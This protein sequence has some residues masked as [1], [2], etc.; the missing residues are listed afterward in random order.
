MQDFKRALA[1]LVLMGSIS[2]TSYPMPGQITRR[3]H[4]SYT[5][6]IDR[7]YE[8]RKPLQVC[9]CEIVFYD[10]KENGK[11]IETFV[12]LNFSDTNPTYYYPSNGAVDSKVTSDIRQVAAQI[13]F[14][15][16]EQKAAK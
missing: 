16:N 5:E 13:E 15:Y 9:N 4:K 6:W 14:D 7:R 1:S 3:E 8:N 2:C 12:V 10:K 11:G